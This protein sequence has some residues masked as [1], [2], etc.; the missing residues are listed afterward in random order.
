MNPITTLKNYFEREQ[1]RE[2]SPEEMI[3]F[4]MACTTPERVEYVARAER[5]LAETPR[6]KPLLLLPASSEEQK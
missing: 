2:V 4:W 3:K 1:G 5:A 6:T